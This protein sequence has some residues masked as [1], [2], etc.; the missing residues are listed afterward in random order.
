[1]LGQSFCVRNWLLRHL[2]S[3]CVEEQFYL[4]WPLVVWLV[5][6]R[7][8]LLW[9]AAWDLVVALGLRVV[10]CCFREGR[11]AR[12]ADQLNTLPFHMDTLLVGGMLALLLRGECG[13]TVAAAV[14]MGG[15]WW[16]VP[17]W[18]DLLLS[19]AADSTVDAAIGFTLIAL[20]SAGLIG[21]A[22]SRERWRSDCLRLRPCGCWGGTA[23]G[24]MSITC[25]WAKAW[26]RRWRVVLAR[27]LHSGRWRGLL[28]ACGQLRGDVSSGE[29]E[30]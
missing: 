25:V 10:S 6:D 26:V 28:T 5:R 30:L 22:L 23:M 12:E 16:R 13:G 17:G 15:C 7:L 29:A 8:R 11:S 20:A 14:Q 21:W 24:F 19:P 4:L 18:S 3:L 27:M 2:W 9:M 1:M